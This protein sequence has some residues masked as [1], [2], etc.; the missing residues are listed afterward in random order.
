MLSAQNFTKKLLKT[1]IF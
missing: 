1:R